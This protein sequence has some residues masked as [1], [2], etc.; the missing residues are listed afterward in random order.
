MFLYIGLM[1]WGARRLIVL[2]GTGGGGGAFANKKCPEGQAF[3][4]FF[5]MPGVWPGFCPGWDAR[6]WNW[7]A[8]KVVIV[9]LKS[10]SVITYVAVVGK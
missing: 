1:D 10:M 7:L 5:K 2:E 9:F 4:Q 6:G 8:H 3:D